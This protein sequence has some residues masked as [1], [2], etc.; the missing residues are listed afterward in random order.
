MRDGRDIAGRIARRPGGVALNI[1]VQLQA[2]G[3]EVQL[4]SALG[5]DAEADALIAA[6][7]GIDCSHV[8]RSDDPTDSYMAI[9]NP[10]GSVFGAIAD[11]A[12]LERAGMKVLQPLSVLSDEADAIIL[13]G[14]LPIDVLTSPLVQNAARKTKT[15]LVPASPGKAKRLAGLFKHVA[16]LLY[17]NKFEA[18]LILDAQ[19]LDTRTAAIAL[20][21]SGAQSAIVTDGANPVAAASGVTV[22]THQPPQVQTR[23]TTGAG[24]V[25]LATHIL[26]EHRGETAQDALAQAAKA[27]AKHISKDPT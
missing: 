27:A 6:L 4:L 18:E 16:A 15:A 8:Y 3:A 10:D 21:Q 23:S 20:C 11:C 26:S 25:F 14:N 12:S 5:R 13:D 19:F 22:C 1:A 24:D 2:L 17:V 9:E 7:P